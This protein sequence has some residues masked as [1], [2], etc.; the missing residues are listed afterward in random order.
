[1]ATSEAMRTKA[2]TPIPEAR[3]AVISLSAAS[4]LSP[5]RMPTS[6]AMGMVTVKV[7]GSVKRNIWRTLT[8]DELL[9]TTRARIFARSRMKRMK[10]KRAPPRNAWER[11]SLRM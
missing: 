10:V 6:T 5:S 9:C 2:S 7:F 8:S 11:I 3:M 1:M 4:R